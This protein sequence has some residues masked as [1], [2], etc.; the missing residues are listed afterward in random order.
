[1]IDKKKMIWYYTSM[2]VEVSTSHRSVIVLEQVEKTN[3][4]EKV[5]LVEIY[6]S[7]KFF[8]KGDYSNF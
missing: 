8:L 6:A 3:I 7:T 5:F 2:K 1:M 4:F